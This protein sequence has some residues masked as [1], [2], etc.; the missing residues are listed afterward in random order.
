MEDYLKILRHNHGFKNPEIWVEYARQENFSKVN[1]KKNDS[2]P[3]CSDTSHK[4]IGSYIYYS[5]F[6]TLRECTRCS[7][8]YVDVLIDQDVRGQHFEIAYKSDAYFEYQRAAIFNK[9]IE[10]IKKHKPDCNSVFDIGAATGVLLEKLKEKFKDLKCSMSDI[11]SQACNIAEKKGIEADCC[12]ISEIKVRE[13]QDIVLALD[14][15]YYDLNVK[16]S[17]QALSD[18]T[19]DEGVLI[20]RLPNKYR[21]IKFYW[22]IVGMRRFPPVLKFFNPEHVLMFRKSF[23]EKSLYDV[24]F[25]KVQVIPSPLLVGRIPLISSIVYRLSYIIYK[26]FGIVLTPSMFIIAKR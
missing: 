4:I 14:V 7:L 9:I 26:I 13:K 17:L 19:S 2:C 3:Y 22:L 11:S 21:L 25:S 10:L 24:G 6:H 15:L 18:V 20:L 16:S 1:Y 5:T 8:C 23:I 12:K